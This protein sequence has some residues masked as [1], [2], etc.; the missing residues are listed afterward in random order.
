MHISQALPTIEDFSILPSVISEQDIDQY[1]RLGWKYRPTSI[2]ASYKENWTEWFAIREFVQNSL[3]ETDGFEILYSTDE[4]ISYIIDEGSGID[5]KDMFLGQQ[6]GA[7]EEEIHCLRGVFGEGMKLALIPLLNENKPVIVRTVGIDYLFTFIEEV[8]AR[9]GAFKYIGIFTKPNRVSQGTAVAIKNTDCTKYLEFFAPTIA[10]T[11]PEKILITVKGGYLTEWDECK[12]RQAFDI[13]GMIFVRDIFVQYSKS[14]FGYNFWFDSTRDALGSDRVQLKNVWVAKREF[15]LLLEGSAS[16]HPDF[17]H[18]LIKRIGYGAGKALNGIEFS[19]EESLEWQLLDQANPSMLSKEVA[20][21]LYLA[22]FTSVGQ[23]FSWSENA[24]EQKALEHARILDLRDQYPNMSKLLGSHGLIRLPEDIVKAAEL[25]DQTVLFT[26]EDIVTSTEVASLTRERIVEKF[27]VV[28]QQLDALLSLVKKYSACKRTKIHFY[29]GQ[30]EKE[31]RVAGFY[32]PGSDEIF[33]NMKNIFDLDD[34]LR[35]FMHETAHAYCHTTIDYTGY[36]HDDCRDLSQGFED[37]LERVATICLI[38]AAKHFAVDYDELSSAVND[39]DSDREYL[40]IIIQ[41]KLQVVN[42]PHGLVRPKHKSDKDKRRIDETLSRIAKGCYFSPVDIMPILEGFNPFSDSYDPNRNPRSRKEALD[43]AKNDKLIMQKLGIT[44]PPAFNTLT[45]E[46][47]SDWTSWVEGKET[48][49][50]PLFFEGEDP[51]DFETCLE[52]IEN[53]PDPKIKHRN[54]K[55]ALELINPSEFY[56]ELRSQD[57]RAAH[58][59]QHDE[60]RYM[61]LPKLE[62][63]LYVV[64]PLMDADKEVYDCLDYRGVWAWASFKEKIIE[65][66]GM[67]IPADTIGWYRVLERGEEARHPD[68]RRY[69]AYAYG[70][71]A[72][73]NWDFSYNSLASMIKQEDDPQ[74]LDAVL[75]TLHKIMVDL[76][77]PG[78]TKNASEGFADYIRLILDNY[79]HIMSV[80]F[81]DDN[82]TYY[83]DPLKRRLTRAEA[84]ANKL[85]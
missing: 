85:R 47:L 68:N 83:R 49:R 53:H 64:L 26:A 11:D 30:Y 9:K 61:D 36:S 51:T 54:L 8:S 24:V 78:R 31:E 71:I 13:P 6:K 25:T 41:H 1:T 75:G 10:A 74:V 12:V 48:Y 34:L 63:L 55:A 29:V 66:A 16:E 27:S 70:K 20:Q 56:E 44:I 19:A 28:V 43:I 22:I 82:N 15:F 50:D 79:D 2:L 40:E 5:I 67:K 52:F 84:F 62:K 4:N 81:V 38:D 17:I 39:L 73:R 77:Y 3:D 23:D 76:Q 57:S 45:R 46:S 35:V 37:S 14:F 80:A 60:G 58:I 18:E 65:I 69:T 72:P 33:I 21:S 42:N 32:A 59:A 7:T